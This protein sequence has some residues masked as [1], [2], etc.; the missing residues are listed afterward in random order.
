M[1]VNKYMYTNVSFSLSVKQAKYLS[2][3]TGR[4]LW[5]IY[6]QPR[7]DQTKYLC[8]QIWAFHDRLQNHWTLLNVSMYSKS[9]Y[10]IV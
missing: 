4:G 3:A 8:S 1:S 2:C 7:P 5:R 9:P 10:Q 6:V